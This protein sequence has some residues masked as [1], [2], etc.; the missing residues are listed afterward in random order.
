MLRSGGDVDHGEGMMIQKCG[1]AW[2]L[3][4]ALV[5]GANSA[6]AFGPVHSVG[7]SVNTQGDLLDASFFGRPFPYG[8]TGWGRCIH[9]VP[10]ET[11]WGVRWRRIRTCR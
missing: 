7:P 3:G 6:S 8:Y 10:V 9:Y 2:L 11:P 4:L 5:S 1:T